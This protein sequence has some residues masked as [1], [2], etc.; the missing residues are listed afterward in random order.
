MRHICL[1]YPQMR[2]FIS[3]FGRTSVVGAGGSDVIITLGRNKESEVEQHSS[4]QRN[5][6]VNIYILNTQK[7]SPVRP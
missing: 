6:E 3:F 7:W 2:H 1:D 5:L 4:C